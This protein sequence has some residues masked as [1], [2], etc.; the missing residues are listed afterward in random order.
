MDGGFDGFPVTALREI[1]TLQRSKH[2]HI[3]NLREVVVGNKLDE[4]ALPLHYLLS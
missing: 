3:V 4:W 2:K 1:E